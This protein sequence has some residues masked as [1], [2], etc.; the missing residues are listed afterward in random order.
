MPRQMQNL[1]TG[2]LKESNKSCINECEKKYQA[3]VP[4]KQASIIQFGNQEPKPVQ[5]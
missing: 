2:N 4:Q 1:E 5:D 3:C